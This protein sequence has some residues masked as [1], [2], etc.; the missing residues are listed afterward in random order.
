MWRCS[1]TPAA[2]CSGPTLEDH[3]T[4]CAHR[5]RNF[6]S[7]LPRI[8]LPCLTPRPTEPQT[9]ACSRVIRFLT[10]R[11]PGGCS[12]LTEKPTPDATLAPVPVSASAKPARIRTVRRRP[13]MDSGFSQLRRRRHQA[14]LA[15]SERLTEMIPSG[16]Q[17]ALAAHSTNPCFRYRPAPT[18]HSRTS[19]QHLRTKADNGRQ[20]RQWG[21]KDSLA[22]ASR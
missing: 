4:H 13:M 6:T 8:W 10:R 1:S 7:S 2:T 5:R 15:S 9:N 18:A 11:Q 12:S 17:L 19:V 16:P 14:H 21:G 20:S 22:L 3:A